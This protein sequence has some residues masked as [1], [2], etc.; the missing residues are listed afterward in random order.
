MRSQPISL[1]KSPLR[2]GTIHTLSKFLPLLL[3]KGRSYAKVLK[4]SL[5]VTDAHADKMGCDADGEYG[6]QGKATAGMDRLAN[7]G[8]YKVRQYELV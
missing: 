1:I 4:I 5:Y 2:F 3:L 8:P 6:D 7:D